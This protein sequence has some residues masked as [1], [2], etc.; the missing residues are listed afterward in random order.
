MLVSTGEL[1]NDSSFNWSVVWKKK[2]RQL[3]MQTWIYSSIQSL[4][5][6]SSRDHEYPYQISQW[7]TRAEKSN[8]NFKIYMKE[9][10]LKETPNVAANTGWSDCGSLGT[11][12]LLAY[13]DSNL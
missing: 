9:Q 4:I 10:F 8:I 13:I 12:E 11:G 7:S 2:S 1:Y 5:E 6:I 3:W